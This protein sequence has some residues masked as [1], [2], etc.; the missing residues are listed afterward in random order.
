MSP[1]RTPPKK[2][3]KSKT[4]LPLQPLQEELLRLCVSAKQASQLLAQSPVEQRNLALLKM[5]AALIAKQ[6][7]ILFKNDIDLEA[8]KKAGLSQ[9]LLDRL[10]LTPERVK[11]MSVGLREIAALPDPINEL[12]RDW[13][14]SGGLRIQK[15]R[16]PLGVIA[17]IYEAR[18][19][20][21]V[22]AA[23][24]CL[25]SGNAVLLRGGKEAIDS[26]TALVHLLTACLKEAGLPEGAIQMVPSTDREAVRQLIK[27]DG[28]IDLVI[29]RGGEEMVRAIREGSSIPVLSHGKGLCAVY[30]DKA[31]DLDMAEKIAFNAKAQRP[32]VCNAAETILVH[33][34]AAKDFVP[35]LVQRFIAAGV[36]VRGD[37]ESRALAGKDVRAAVAVD[38]DTEFHGPIVALRVVGSLDE[39]VA[40]I[41]RHGSHHSD[42]IVTQDDLAADSFLARVDSA[43]VLHNAST[44]LHDGSVFGLGSEMGI[45]TQKLHARGT[46]GLAELTSTKYVVRGQG[47]I[48]Q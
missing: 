3:R 29:P 7:D 42:S 30:V 20:V 26:N 32:G 43:A 6:D 27:L 12:V 28:F 8:G 40:H 21:T 15:V 16:V 34:A 44:R 1:Q 39:A 4:T 11:A 13:T 10:A 23:G 24:L 35:G 33:R 45:S 48:R 37:P 17:M 47:H 9:A 2:K 25:K 46:M 5:A 38:W 18:P 22:D 36:E 41:N 31:A 19:N 14:R